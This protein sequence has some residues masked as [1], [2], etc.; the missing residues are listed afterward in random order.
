VNV[1]CALKHDGVIGPFFFAEQTTTS[2]SYLDVLQLYAVPQLEQEGAEVVFEHDG[3][4]PHYSAIVR[5]FLDAK[6]PQ[7]WMAAMATMLAR[8]HAFRLLLLGLRQ[9][10][11]LECSYQ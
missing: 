4:S 6:F 1:W 3:A 5:E 11:C 8:P 9:S 10:M 7:R 2:H